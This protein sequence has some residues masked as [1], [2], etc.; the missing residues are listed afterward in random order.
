MPSLHPIL[1]LSILAL[2]PAFY[3]VQAAEKAPA[4]TAEALAGKRVLWLGDS[5]TQAGT[6]VSFVEYFLNTQFPA[7]NFDIISL[8]LASETVSGLSEKQHPF[9]RPHVLERLHRAL[10]ATKPEIVVASYGMNDGIYHPQSAER[11]KA[12]QEGLQKLMAAVKARGAKLILLT[13]PPFDALPVAAKL[14][15]AGAPDFAYFAPFEDY[16]AVLADYASWEKTLAAPDVLVV[17]LHTALRDY[18]QAQRVTNPQFSFANDGIHPNDAGHLLMA[19]TILSALGM[20]VPDS[21]LNAELHKINADPLWNLI[22]TR[23]AARST[24]WL[25]FVG[26]TREKAVKTDS[27]TGVETAAAALQEQIDRLRRPTVTK[28]KVAC[29]GDSITAGAGAGHAFFSYPAQLQRM[30]GDR[31]EVRNFG[32]SGA[33]LLNAGDK[34]YQ[35]E[36][37]M[38]NALD[39]KPDVVVIMLG[40]NDSKPQNW[41]FKDQFAADYKDLI[42]KFKN[43]E[44]KPR[45]FICHPPLV[46]GAG[47]FG[48]NEPVVQQEMPLIENVAKEE[49]AGLIDVHGAFLGQDALFPDRV[50]PNREG[51]G[52]IAKTVYNAL[53]GKKWEGEMPDTAVSQWQGYQRLDFVVANRACLLVVPK[54]VAKGKPWSWRTEFFGHE[55][56]GDVALLGKGYH[57]AYMDVQ[58]MY[59]APVALDLMDKFYDHLLQRHQ[60]SAKPVLEGFSRGGLFALNWAARNPAKVASLYLDAPVA[61]FKSWPGGKGKG[62]GSAR[63]WETVQKVYGLT[64]AQALSYALN[65]IDNLKPLAGAK[66][67]ILGV[68]GT[69]D[70]TVP[71][72]ENI[73]ILARRYKELGGEIQLIAKPG[74]GHH[75]HSLQDPTPIVDFIVEHQ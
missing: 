31:W 44:S 32:V 50:H 1:F 4:F 47:N 9:P 65:P 15:K 36:A 54:T 62:E 13:P 74:V 51:A 59:G 40:T 16:D 69:A 28:T 6:Y 46:P 10:D 30:L 34:P 43:L 25:S 19:R 71:P 7:Q 73:E 52:V 38:Q 55:P 23:R 53:T 56:Q 26:Y 68:Y 49:N 5:I 58:N 45:I 3:S 35:K 2:A 39:F 20:A 57:V 42:A 70:T 22:R 75:P 18:V 12:F 64:E 63:D 41:K 61:D 24:G 11:M 17:D 21:D 60:L 72:D 8:G 33:T 48:I 27:I 66:I 67:P 14:Q 29:I 37:A